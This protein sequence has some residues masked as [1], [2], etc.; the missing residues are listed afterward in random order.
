MSEFHFARQIQNLT[1]F[2]PKE[3]FVALIAETLQNEDSADIVVKGYI[4]PIVGIESSLEHHYMIEL[5]DES[6]TPL[7]CRNHTEYMESEWCYMGQESCYMPI[8]V[9]PSGVIMNVRSAVIDADD[10][11][12]TMCIQVHKCDWEECEDESKLEEEL[13]KLKIEALAEFQSKDKHTCA[14]CKA[15]LRA[16]DIKTEQPSQD[17]SFEE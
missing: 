3:R 5:D 2:Q 8:F 14:K 13:G 1:V 11:G 12:Q 7:P 15:L 6:E 9:H 16:P 10:H 4:C 17:C